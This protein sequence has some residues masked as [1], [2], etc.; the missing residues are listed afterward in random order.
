MT[1]QAK[2]AIAVVDARRGELAA[3]AK[4][5]L[6]RTKL[7]NL[8]EVCRVLVV[9]AAQRPTIPEVIRQYKVRYPA[10]GHS[11]AEQSLRN[12]REG[13]NPYSVLYK[14]WVGAAEFVLAARRPKRHQPSASELLS[15]DDVAGIADTALRHQVGLVLAQNRSLK[16]QLDILRSLGNAPVVR[17]VGDA[18]TRIEASQAPLANHL[19]L[20]ETEVEAV[21][22]FIEPR[23]LSARGL[24]RAE[25]GAIESK[26]GRAFSAPGLA[27]ALEK[28]VRS[29]GR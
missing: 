6:V 16:S 2:E 18:G 7:D 21:E 26:D 15:E 22:N 1:P 13:S 4:T 9:E 27:D 14:A 17:L 20:T 11:L 23:R 8:H 29:Y 5:E 3:A 28:I 10:I 19:A 25:D 24:T 12:K